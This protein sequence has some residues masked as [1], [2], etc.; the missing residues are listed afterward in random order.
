MFVFT[1]ICFDVRSCFNDV[2]YIYFPC[3]NTLVVPG[4]AV[5]YDFRIGTMFSSSLPPAVCR[6]DHVLF[7]LFVFYAYSG[8]HVLTV[9]TNCMPGVL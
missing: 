8:V 2:I 5:C 1:P 7:M 3:S 9:Y 4:F 6:S